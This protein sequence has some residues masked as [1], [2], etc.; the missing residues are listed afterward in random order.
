MLNVKGQNGKYV[1]IRGQSV[2]K[3]NMW[4]KCKLAIESD[5]EYKIC[6]LNENVKS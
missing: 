4:Q 6:V 1:I 5:N 3:E 2:I